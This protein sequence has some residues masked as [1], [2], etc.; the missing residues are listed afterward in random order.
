MNSIVSY[1]SVIKANAGRSAL[2]TSHK[3]LLDQ[4]LMLNESEGWS[5]VVG[6][7]NQALRLSSS[8]LIRDVYN[9]ERWASGAAGS[10]SA[11]DAVRRRLHAMVIGMPGSSLSYSLDR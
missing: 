1:V 3:S 9:D 2:Y 8:R 5:P 10:G 4:L 7:I 11:A 6:T